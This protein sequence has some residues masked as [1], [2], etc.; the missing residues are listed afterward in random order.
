MR[1]A[2]QLGSSGQVQRAASSNAGAQGILHSMGGGR[3]HA[4]TAQTQTQQPMTAA[5]T[6]HWST[7]FGFS[8]RSMACG[9]VHAFQ[10][11]RETAGSVF[12]IPLMPRVAC[13][14]CRS[15]TRALHGPCT[16]SSATHLMRSRSWWQMTVTLSSS[17]WSRTEGH[18]SRC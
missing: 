17:A 16:A 15:C 18:R 2:L 8:A 4:D 14:H 1:A 11:C 6:A 3:A 13:A 10:M 5:R 7:A 12:T 9:S